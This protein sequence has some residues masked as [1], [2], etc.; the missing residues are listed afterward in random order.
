M[1]PKPEPRPVDPNNV[2]ADTTQIEYVTYDK[3]DYGLDQNT[4]KQPNDPSKGVL[5]DADAMILLE[6]TKA[7]LN[8]GKQAL[9][10]AIVNGADD[11]AARDAFRKASGYGGNEEFFNKIW[12]G[13]FTKTWN[14]IKFIDYLL[15]GVERALNDNNFLLFESKANRIWKININ[16]D[17]SINVSFG[18]ENEDD[19]PV[20][21]YYKE[22]Y[23]YRVLGTPNKW[24]VDN[25]RDILGGNFA[26]WVKTDL[27]N[28]L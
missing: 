16:I 12:E 11:T 19:N 6:K 8:A 24:A 25:S 5:S 23:R 18:Y 17:H 21:R 1:E 10:R 7:S 26:G 13:L 20:I 9:L 28:N 15:Q 3:Q 22:V 4:P 14:G 2:F 27:T